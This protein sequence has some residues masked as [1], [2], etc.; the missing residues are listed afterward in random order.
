MTAAQNGG[1]MAMER[2]WGGWARAAFYLA[3]FA[4][5]FHPFWRGT[6]MFRDA[7]F[8]FAPFSEIANKNIVVKTVITAQNIA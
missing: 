2:R 1:N 5:V 8:F 3:F 6:V 4:L 7:F